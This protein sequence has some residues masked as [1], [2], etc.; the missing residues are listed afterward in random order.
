MQ[1]LLIALIVGAALWFTGRRIWRALQSARARRDAACG[2]ECGCSD[3]SATGGR[4]RD[5]AGR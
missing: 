1:G 4:E 3:A 2:A 5:W